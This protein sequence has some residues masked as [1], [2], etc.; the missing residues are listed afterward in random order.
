MTDL[1]DDEL[2]AMSLPFRLRDGS[3]VT[4]ETATA[5]QAREAMEV[6]AEAYA[7]MRARR[8]FRLVDRV[9]S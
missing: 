9:H 8:A 5:E 3:I 4:A 1:P 6:D 7:A 2:P